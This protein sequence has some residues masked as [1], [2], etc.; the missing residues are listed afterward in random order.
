LA[1]QVEDLLKRSLELLRSLLFGCLG[2]GAL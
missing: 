1:V 2:D